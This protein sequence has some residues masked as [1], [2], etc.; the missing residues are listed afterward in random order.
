MQSV[1]CRAI[2]LYLV[3]V[4]LILGIT[5]AAFAT[6]TG[7][8][9]IPTADAVSKDL[10][11]L[12]GFSEFGGERSP[13][14]FVG[15]KYGP[16]ENVE[17]G[18][19]DKAAGSGTAAGPVLQGKFRL[20]LRENCAAALGAANISDNSDRNGHSFPYFVLSHDLGEMNAHLGYS[21]QKANQA[22]FVGVD[23][24]VTPRLTLRA[25]WTEVEDG[26]ESLA[27][28]GFIREID[29]QWLVEAWASFPTA[30][31]EHTAYVAKFDYVVPLK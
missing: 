28:L 5:G 14:W 18:I 29:A 24:A 31:G 15:A 12:Q 4:S 16:L 23:R 20:P 25:D 22:W 21:W 11:V 27:S 3:G 8:N 7:L 9:N 17:I 26:D 19:D 2:L 1:S 30:H 6:P 10:L 13:G